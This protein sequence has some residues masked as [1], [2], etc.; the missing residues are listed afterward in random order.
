MSDVVP[1]RNMYKKDSSEEAV[2]NSAG[3]GGVGLKRALKGG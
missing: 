3:G 1:N 2:V